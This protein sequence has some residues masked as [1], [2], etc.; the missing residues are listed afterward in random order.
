MTLD[1]FAIEFA[2]GLAKFCDAQHEEAYAVYAQNN[3]DD[4]YSGPVEK[5]GRLSDLAD[6]CEIETHDALFDRGVWR[7]TERRAA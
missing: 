6:E 2:E 4:R 7:A 5:W 1:H 3:Y